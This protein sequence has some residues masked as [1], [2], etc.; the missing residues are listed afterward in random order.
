MEQSQIAGDQTLIARSRA[1]SP[2]RKHAL[3]E[4][5]PRSPLQPFRGA[6]PLELPCTL[7]R[8]ARAPLRSRGSLAALVRCLWNGPPC[9]RAFIAPRMVHYA[10]DLTIELEREEEG[11]WFAEVP[12]LS[13]V[14]CYGQALNRRRVPHRRKSRTCSRTACRY[15]R[16]TSFDGISRTS[17]WA[18]ILLNVG[19][20]ASTPNRRSRQIGCASVAR[21]AR[22]ISLKAQVRSLST[23]GRNQRGFQSKTT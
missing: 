4:F 21:G 20:F 9:G 12:A 18:S 5:D 2:F 6:S 11:R 23:S 1:P 17:S 10:R 7:T 22:R 8:G 13:G 16:P 3:I 19:T 15:S 14:L